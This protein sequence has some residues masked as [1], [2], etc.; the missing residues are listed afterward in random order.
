MTLSGKLEE[1]GVL[2]LT[3]LCDMD[4]GGDGPR[5]YRKNM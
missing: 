5:K 3:A 2:S 1:H 4:R